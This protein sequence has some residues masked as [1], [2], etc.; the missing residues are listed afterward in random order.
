MGDESKNF[1]EDGEESEED[2]RKK[3]EKIAE[4]RVRLGLILSQIAEKNEITVSEQEV[5][6]A[7]K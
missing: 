1:G 5:T 3:Y 2:A 6:A 7:A 4:R